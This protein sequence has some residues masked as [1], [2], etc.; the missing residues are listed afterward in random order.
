MTN[1]DNRYKRPSWSTGLFVALACIVAALAGFMMFTEGKKVKKVEGVPTPVA[2]RMEDSEA[3]V[4]EEEKKDK[5]GKKKDK[6][7]VNGDVVLEQKVS[8]G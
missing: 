8:R 7:I 2:Q 1:L 3:I 6:K 5:S 4:F